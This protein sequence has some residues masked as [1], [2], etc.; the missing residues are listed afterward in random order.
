MVK[1]SKILILLG[2][3]CIVGLLL[4][5]GVRL[6]AQNSAKKVSIS[7]NDSEIKVAAKPQM[8]Q[9][10]NRQQNSNWRGQRQSERT[11]TEDGSTFYNA[12]VD[13]NIFRPL[14]WRPPKKEPEYILIGTSVAENGG[15]S[16]LFIEE[17]RSGKFYIATVGGKIGD[18]VV[19]EIEEKKVTLDKNG[20]TITL[21]TGSMQLLNS[22]GSSGNNNNRSSNDGDNRNSSKSDNNAENRKKQEEEERMKQQMERMREMRRRFESGSREDRIRMIRE[23]SGRRGRGR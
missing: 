12:I 13:N 1:F 3:G 18:T 5:F 10:R 14:G 9:F 23:Y 11:N 20:E 6:Q 7:T 16:E 15:R 2:I 17:R 4:I 8:G 19:K 21:R 22:S